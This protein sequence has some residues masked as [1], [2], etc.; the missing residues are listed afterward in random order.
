MILFWLWSL[1][2]MST[3]VALL[4]NDLAKLCSWKI[5]NS[6]TSCWISFFS[7]DFSDWPKPKEIY[8]WFFFF[9]F[10]VFQAN[11]LWICSD[12]LVSS[13]IFMSHW[14]GCWRGLSKLCKCVSY[15][16]SS[17]DIAG[18]MVTL[19]HLPWW[20]RSFIRGKWLRKSALSQPPC[21]Q[22]LVI[23]ETGERSTKSWNSRIK[24]SGHTADF[25]PMASPFSLPLASASL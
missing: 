8:T 24:R 11:T 19:C 10:A 13:L 12:F 23:Y 17:V 7:G 2:P 5:W 18:K 25:S 16:V 6:L 14:R 15:R 21:S 22:F 4:W 20:N 1:S 3:W 9:F